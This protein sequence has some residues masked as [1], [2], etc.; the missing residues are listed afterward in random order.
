MTINPKLKVAAAVLL[1]IVFIISG[2]GKIVDT[3]A[4][5]HHIA[6]FGLPVFFV[7]LAPA[8]PPFEIMLGI[9]LLGS[10]SRGLA[11]LIAFFSLILFTLLFF[12]GY[13][14]GGVD[15]C[16]CFG[17]FQVTESPW[18]LLVRNAILGV[19]A[20]VAFRGTEKTRLFSRGQLAF[21]LLAC[22]LTGVS[23]MTSFSPLMLNTPVRP[24]QMVANT[25]LKE[26]VTLEPDRKYLLFFFSTNCFICL[27]NLENAKAWHRSGLVDEVIGVTGSDEEAL[28]AY[29]AKYEVPFRTKS[30]PLE[31]FVKVVQHMPMNFYVMNGQV[32]FVQRGQLMSPHTFVK[33]NM[34][35]FEPRPTRAAR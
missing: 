30:I 34:K 10:G 31:E 5:G 19:L 25:E 14:F 23:V 18:L 1:G 4:F 32:R 2:I 26:M 21:L 11:A 22:A 29:V 33:M 17:V 9:A 27:N 15:G 8:I 13:L 6:S 7:F 3:G 24:G 20:W 28:K 35:A 16:Q 12:Y